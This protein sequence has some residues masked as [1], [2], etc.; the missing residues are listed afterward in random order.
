MKDQ[1]YRRAACGGVDPSLTLF[2]EKVLA[3]GSR[4]RPGH[5]HIVVRTEFCE[6]CPVRRQCLDDAMQAERALGPAHRFGIWGGLTPAQRHSL[7]QRGG[8]RCPRCHE[9]FDPMGFVI[10]ELECDRCGYSCVV[11]P[12]PEEGDAWRDKHNAL[13]ERVVA[14]LIDNV[15]VGD[16]VPRPT[17]LARVL[18]A[19]KAD[20][21]RVYEA[22]VYDG[23]LEQAGKGYVRRGSTKALRT[24]RPPHVAA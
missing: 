10:G 16:E 14:W 21:V 4:V 8:H 3:E 22:L 5:D 2:F 18:G 6:R 7:H 17:T 1:W 13:A 9:L 19:R 20:V 23:T 11:Q 15:T 24:W 12:L